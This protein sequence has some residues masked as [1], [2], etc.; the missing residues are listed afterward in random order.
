[1]VADG[2]CK[3]VS[4]EQPPTF[5]EAVVA[6]FCNSLLQFIR[7]RMRAIAIMTLKP[8]ADRSSEGMVSDS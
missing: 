2:L 7:L 5:Y 1:M 4:I 8:S 3:I 6:L